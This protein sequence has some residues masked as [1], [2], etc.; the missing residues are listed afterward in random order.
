MGFKK[1]NSRNLGHKRGIIR[2]DV[3]CDSGK[4]WQMA[5]LKEGSDQNINK[6]WAWTFWELN[7][8]I[9]NYNINNY[10]ICKD[11]DSSYNIQPEKPIY[12]WNIRGLNNNTW[13]KISMKSIIK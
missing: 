4:T 9:A 5:K 3:S 1:K 6:S 2:V 12:S 13:H 8:K 11:I 7:T 10:I